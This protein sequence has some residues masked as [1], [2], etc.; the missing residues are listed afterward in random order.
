MCVLPRPER[1]TR[2][3]FGRPTRRAALAPAL[4]LAGTLAACAGGGGDVT[5]TTSPPPPP[6]P[7][8]SLTLTAAPAAVRVQAGQSGAVT[9][10]LTRGGPAAAVVL[11]AEV[12]GAPSGVAAAFAPAT[13][14]ADGAESAVTL[15]TTA[16]TPAGDYTVTISGSG[17]ASAS[18]SVTLHVDPAPV[19]RYTLAVTPAPVAVTAGAAAA[20][21]AVTL[22]RSHFAGAVTLAAAGAPAGLTVTLPAAPVAGDSAALGVQAAATVPAGDYPVTLTGSA[23][24]L[25]PV[26]A[27]VVVRVAAAAPPPPQPT[28]P[29]STGV[30]PGY[31]T[32]TVVD[33]AGRPLAGVE[34]YADNTLYYNTNAIGYTDAQGRYKIDVRQ[35]IG[36][37]RVGAHLK[38]EY[39]GRTYQLDLH[40]DTAR[41]FSGADGAVRN[42]DWRLTGRTPEGGSYGVA[43]YVYLNWAPGEYVSVGDV[44][45]TFTPVGPLVDGSTG[46]VGVVRLQGNYVSNIP[47][48]RYKVTARWAPQD[49]RAPRPMGVRLRDA[50]SYTESTTLDWPA[51]G[52]GRP[53]EAEL[54][55][56]L[57]ARAN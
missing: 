21:A 34:V 38:R 49:G 53:Q 16:A 47:L 14:P 44:E 50:N 33:A 35:P 19:A 24:G 27:T 23:A 52:D 1:P 20:S 4:G 30:T 10:R 13:V 7:S 51:N 39:N 2:P 37:W 15:T 6:S 43:T 26:T 56:Y 18:T 42:F 5:G 55:V 41:A 9:V 54:E 46:Q 31:V 36:T 12:G 11:G 17:G 45:V 8:S 29:P 40:P 3:L 48:G 32:G 22:A 57:P 28:P 25:A